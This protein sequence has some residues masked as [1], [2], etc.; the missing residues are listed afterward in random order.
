MKCDHCGAELSDEDNHVPHLM[1]EC[2]KVIK[3]FADEMACKV[4]LIEEYKKECDARK[5]VIDQL[6]REV[7]VCHAENSNLHKQLAALQTGAMEDFKNPE[8]FPN[9]IDRHYHEIM[10]ASM[11]I[12]LILLVWIAKKA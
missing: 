4:E 8:G 9:W 6:T 1:G 2:T 10:L 12:E 5:R 3:T 7:E 11:I